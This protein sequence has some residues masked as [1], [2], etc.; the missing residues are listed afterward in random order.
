MILEFIKMNP[1]GNITVI[2]L[3]PVSS[4]LYGEVARQVMD[5]DMLGAE[6]V[7]FAQRPLGPGAVARLEMMG[8][9]FCGNGCRSFGAWL[10]CAPY[11]GRRLESGF[12]EVV[13]EASGYD[14]QVLVRGRKERGEFWVSSPMPLPSRIQFIPLGRNEIG[15]VEFPGITHAVVVNEE[16][17]SE[18]FWQVSEV[19][20]CQ[21]VP[22]FGVM[23]LSEEKLQVVPVVRVQETQS[24]VWE[25]SCASGSVAV[26][27]ILATKGNGKVKNLELKQ[28]KGTLWVDIDL[29]EE[30]GLAQ[31]SGP[32]SLVAHGKVWVEC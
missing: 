18:V 30:D 6:Q 4:D 3:T 26:G 19:C 14:G 11:L 1:S 15:L 13:I 5:T 32:V 8:G 27:S 31:V 7:G 25:G 21:D 10:M 28:P 16:P 23:F 17:T 20:N 2:V 22:A 12:L 29:T 9:E 24:L